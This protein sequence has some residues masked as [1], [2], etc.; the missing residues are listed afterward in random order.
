M[1]VLSLLFVFGMS[2]IAKPL[3]VTCPKETENL[4]P[5]SEITKIYSKKNVVINCLKRNASPKDS[6][7]SCRDSIDCV[8][9]DGIGEGM[10]HPKD[11]ERAEA[12][13]G[14]YQFSIEAPEAGAAVKIMRLMKGK[15]CPIP[16]KVVEKFVEATVSVPKLKIAAVKFFQDKKEI[17]KD[18]L[19]AGI[20]K[21]A[22]DPKERFAP[23]L[24]DFEI[25]GENLKNAEVT[26][27]DSSQSLKI[28][29][30]KNNSQTHLTGKLQLQPAA[31][32]QSYELLVFR[33]KEI[34][35]VRIQLE[36]SGT[37]YFV[38]HSRNKWPNKFTVEFIGNWPLKP[39]D[40]EDAIEKFAEAPRI[41]RNIQLGLEEVSTAKFKEMN[42]TY[43]AFSDDCWENRSSGGESTVDFLA[44]LPKA[45]LPL[46]IARSILNG[47]AKK[48]LQKMPPEFHEQWNKIIKPLKKADPLSNVAFFTEVAVFDSALSSQA[49][50]ENDIAYNQKLKLLKEYGFLR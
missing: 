22:C 33:G 11:G 36:I 10:W 41:E 34:L 17:Q 35:K 24:L 14:D 32:Q 49:L 18:K 42:L 20:E 9:E 16:P 27:T 45:G 48:L 28:V 26:V 31:P 47:S 44:D 13:C 39:Y 25:T 12:I 5:R 6:R 23:S 29:E 3:P 8:W 38:F 7:I 46:N 4:F 1:K 2:A 19:P 15:P 30:L 40:K 21:N 37:Q 43:R 50:K